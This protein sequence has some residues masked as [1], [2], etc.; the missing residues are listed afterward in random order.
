MP[1]LDGSHRSAEP[2]RPAHVGD[3][4]HITG[5]EDR[6]WKVVDVYGSIMTVEAI[7]QPGIRRRR[8]ADSVTPAAT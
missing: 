1:R 4:V 3:V 8:F 7:D 5:G 6:L 2:I